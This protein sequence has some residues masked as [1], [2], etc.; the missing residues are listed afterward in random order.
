M[1][2]GY[3]FGSVSMPLFDLNRRLKQGPQRL[4]AWPL[5]RCDDR[6]ICMGDCYMYNNKNE[7]DYNFTNNLDVVVELA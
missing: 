1:R 4:L 7:I 6:Y 3:I 2:S 5:E